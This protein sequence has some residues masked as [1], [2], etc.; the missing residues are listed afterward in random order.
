MSKLTRKQIRINVE[1]NEEMLPERISWDADDAGMDAPREA[2]SLM[3]SLWDREEQNTMRFDLHTKDMYVDEMKNHFLQSLV[4][5]A[6][7]YSRATG[8]SFVPG[9]VHRFCNTLLEK[10][11]DAEKQQN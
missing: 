11:E 7:H 10:I 1:L 4:T 2:K 6:E 8:H 3:L 5:M 9:E